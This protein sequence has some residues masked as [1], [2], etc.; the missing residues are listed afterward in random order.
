MGYPIYGIPEIRNL[1]YAREKGQASLMLALSKSTTSKLT[2][3]YT[4]H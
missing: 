4:K 2:T 1:F 3:G